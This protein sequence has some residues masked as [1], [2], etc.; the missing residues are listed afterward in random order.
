MIPSCG[1]ARSRWSRMSSKNEGCKCDSTAEGRN[2]NDRREENCS[3]A[4]SNPLPVTRSILSIVISI[5][6]CGNEFIITVNVYPMVYVTHP[7][8]G[9]PSSIAQH[10]RGCQYRTIRFRHALGEMILTPTV[11]AP[12]LFKLWRC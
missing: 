5:Y 3:D 10:P 11:L 7:W 1:S 4:A 8:G 6:I 12:T 2:K 9:F